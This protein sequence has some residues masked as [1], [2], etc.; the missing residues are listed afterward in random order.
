M[1]KV[2]G[3]RILLSVGKLLW[4]LVEN[5]DFLWIKWVDRIYTK[6][7]TNVWTYQSPQNSSWYWRKLNGLKEEMQT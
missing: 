4:Q 7:D 1:S 2:S 6:G 5:K 3:T